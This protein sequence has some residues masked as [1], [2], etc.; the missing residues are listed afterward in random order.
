MKSLEAL[1]LLKET[2]LKTKNQEVNKIISQY[3]GYIKKDLKA[4]E[5]I[6]KYIKVVK[7]GEYLVRLNI[8]G[9][10]EIEIPKEEFDLLKETL[11][12]E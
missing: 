11:G 1:I 12:D 2:Y 8:V 9:D 6:K 4:L 7:Q 10:D 3:T 5:I